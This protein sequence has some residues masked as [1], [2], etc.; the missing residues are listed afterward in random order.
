MNRHK[1]LLE[2]YENALFSLMI[3]QVSQKEGELYLQEN[4]LLMQNPE[5]DVPDTI[6]IGCRKAINQAFSRLR[7]IGRAHV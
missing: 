4:E 2:N 5:S 7:Q 6:D 3:E 1:Q